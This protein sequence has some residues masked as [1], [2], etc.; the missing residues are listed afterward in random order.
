MIVDDHHRVKS[1]DF[2]RIF[3]CIFLRKILFLSQLAGC[4]EKTRTRSPCPPHDQG[5]RGMSRA[6]H[7]FKQSEMTRALRAAQAAGLTAYRVEIADN[8]KPVVIVGDMDK[9]KPGDVSSWD[10]AIAELEQ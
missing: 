3:F 6:Q 2:P 8:G 10:D 5:T 7:S 4:L 9:R 1:R